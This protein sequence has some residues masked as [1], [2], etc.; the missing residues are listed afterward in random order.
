MSLQSC[1]GESSRQ[2][3]Y[4]AEGVGDFFLS[5]AACRDLGII[6]A[7]F[8]EPGAVRRRPLTDSVRNLGGLTSSTGGFQSVL[9]ASNSGFPGVVS[10]AVAGPAVP[11]VSPVLPVPSAVPAP[12]QPSVSSSSS[13]QDVGGAQ[14]QVQGKVDARGC[15]LA[16]CGCLLR[17]SAP[18]VPEVLPFKITAETVGKAE[19]WF[20]EEYAASSFNNCPHQPL[21]LMS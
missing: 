6:H 10:A 12:V 5:K 20:R 18:R 4:F 14:E 11:T 3:V 9:D 13:T 15:P 1:N 19:E 17:V 16:A 7:G 21:P 8:P 2:L